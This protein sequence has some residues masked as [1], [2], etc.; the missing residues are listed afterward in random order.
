MSGGECRVAR[1]KVEDKVIDK[2][3]VARGKFEPPD[4]PPQDYCAASVGCYGC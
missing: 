4:P 2:A 3:E 1:D